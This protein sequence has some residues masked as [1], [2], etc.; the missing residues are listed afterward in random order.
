MHRLSSIIATVPLLMSLNN[1][2][3]SSLK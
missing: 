1:K 3:G 2:T